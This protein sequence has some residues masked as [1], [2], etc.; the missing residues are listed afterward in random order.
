[1]NE[2]V[3][4]FADNLGPQKIVHI[5]EPGLDLKAILVVDNI[6]AGPSIGGTR[7]AHDVNLEECVRLARAMTLKN[8][9]AGLPHGG[10]KSVVFADPSMP[11]PEK[12]QIMR[13][14]ACAIG[15]IADFIPGP[16]MGH[17]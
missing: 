11:A 9:A 7:M 4:R 13:A 5:Y 6:A 14:F 10:G 3:F 12:E 16:D 2:T 1:M 8:A 15:D 17:R